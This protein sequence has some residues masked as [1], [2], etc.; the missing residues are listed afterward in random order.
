MLTYTE[1]DKNGILA[2]T[3][4]GLYRTYDISKG[5]EKISFGEGLNA[6]VFAI[7]STPA[8]PGTIWVGTASSGLLVSTD[9]GETWKNVPGIPANIPISSITS[10]PKRPNYLYVGTIQS[11]YLSRDGGRN[12]TRRGGNLPLGNYT[13]ILI[14]PKNTDEIFISSALENDGGIFYST[15]AGMHWK[16]IDS[17]DMKIPSRRVWMMAFDP[18]D[19]NRIFAGSHS[20]GVYRIDRKAET[21]AA[22]EKAAGRRSRNSEIRLLYRVMMRRCFGTAF[23]VNGFEVRGYDSIIKGIGSKI[24]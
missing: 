6:N 16:R 14:D 3:D 22:A 5:W 19:S 1:D 20:S 9:A 17:K 18:L 12:W 4:N 10:D 2:G 21:A 15:D 8:V 23:L 13:S 7:Y 24:L 11:F